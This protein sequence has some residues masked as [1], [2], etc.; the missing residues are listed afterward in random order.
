[1]SL[2]IVLVGTVQKKSDV[3]FFGESF[4]KQSIQIKDQHD[5]YPQYYEIE[6]HK[7]KTSLLDSIGVGAKVEVSINLRGRE[8]TN[9]EGVV[10][11]F[12][13][14]VGWR[15][16]EV[17]QTVKPIDAISELNEALKSNNLADANAVTPDDLPF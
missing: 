5:Q 1:M 4:S 17:Q 11:I 3:E 6:F 16:K 9:K 13:T 12:H 15:I 7:D 8:W 14:L 2:E 10:K